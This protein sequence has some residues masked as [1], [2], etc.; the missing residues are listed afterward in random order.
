MADSLVAP[1][2]LYPD[3]LAQYSFWKGLKLVRSTQTAAGDSTPVW[4]T[5]FGWNT[6]LVHIP[7]SPLNGVSEA[8]Q[9]DFLRRALALLADRSAGLRFVQGAVIYNL[10]DNGPSLL[11]VTQNFGIYRHDFSR[12]PSFSV[13]RAAFTV[14]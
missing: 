10:R 6:S 13:V 9:A 5:E 14:R 1:D 2:A 8:I 4:A 7:N 3:A 12:K 11:D